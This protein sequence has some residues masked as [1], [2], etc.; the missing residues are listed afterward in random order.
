MEDL[1][2]LATK[3][4]T[5]L[6]DEFAEVVNSFLPRFL[7]VERGSNKIKEEITPRLLRHYTT[8]SMLDEPF[9]DGKF[10]V[11]TYRHLLQFLVVR[12]LL[13]EGF[14]A[15]A[16]GQIAIAK[17]N[18]EL[19]GILAGGVQLNVTPAN[20]AIAFLESIHRK[21]SAKVADKTS[22]SYAN[23]QPSRSN[24]SEWTRLEIQQGLEIHIRSDFHSPQS[25][26]EQQ[27]LLQRIEREFTDFIE[28]QRKGKP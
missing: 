10:A 27:S 5:W 26:S 21:S 7:P 6:L 22:L 3:Q 14:S 17:T 20:P 19:E 11:Y 8:Q 1:L 18:D 12:R 28:S 13:A 23:A 24:R 4:P 25:T 15:S 16:I 2:A 9:K